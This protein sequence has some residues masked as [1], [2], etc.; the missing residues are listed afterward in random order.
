MSEFNCILT[1]KCGA[2]NKACN[3]VFSSGCDEFG[4]KIF[5]KDRDFELAL[6]AGPFCS[7]IE[8]FFQVFQAKK[9]FR[10]SSS[11]HHTTK[12]AGSRFAVGVILPHRANGLHPWR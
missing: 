5:G 2:I 6:K 4:N 1:T 3:I 8:D 7:S 11:S 10:A 9:V 12:M